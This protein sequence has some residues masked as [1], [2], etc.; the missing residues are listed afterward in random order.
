MFQEEE[1]L[2][3]PIDQLNANRI[4]NDNSMNENDNNTSTNNT[5]IGKLKNKKNCFTFLFI[6]FV[7]NKF[8]I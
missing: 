1:C 3:I 7:N 6:F 2:P 8:L 5:K 4:I